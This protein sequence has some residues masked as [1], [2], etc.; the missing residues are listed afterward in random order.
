LS[1]QIGKPDAAARVGRKNIRFLLSAPDLNQR[2]R[3]AVG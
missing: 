2:T 3:A 1:Y